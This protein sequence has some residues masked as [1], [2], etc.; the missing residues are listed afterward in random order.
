MIVLIWW[1]DGHSRQR[2]Q[3]VFL[4]YISANSLTNAKGDNKMTL[5]N[6]A[7]QMSGVAMEF[8]M[9]ELYAIQEIHSQPNLFRLLVA[10]VKFVSVNAQMDVFTSVRTVR[11]SKIVLSPL[12]MGYV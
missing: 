10:Y 6:S 11:T 3:C 12:A 2:D 5:T 7:E 9:K 4:L 8:T 1:T